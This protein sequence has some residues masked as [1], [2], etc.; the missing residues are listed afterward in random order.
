M[1][2]LFLKSMTGQ[3][4]VVAVLI[5]GAVGWL[6]AHDRKVIKKTEATI[7]QRSEKQGAQNAAKAKK[8]IDDARKPGAFDRLRADTK[9]CPDCR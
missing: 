6:Y 2:G 8:R 1:I 7:V 3:L 9:T 5:S 4:A